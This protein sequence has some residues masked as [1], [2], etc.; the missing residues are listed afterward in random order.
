MSIFLSN[1][2]IECESKGDRNKTQSDEENLNEIR[3]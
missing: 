2:Y 1:N 3:P